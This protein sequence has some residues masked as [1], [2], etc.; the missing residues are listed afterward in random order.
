VPSWN[1]TSLNLLQ[2]SGPVQ[3][4]IGTGLPYQNSNPVIITPQYSIYPC[5]HTHASKEATH[6]STGAETRSLVR[7]SARPPLRRRH[8]N[9]KYRFLRHNPPF[10]RRRDT[11]R[12]LDESLHQTKAELQNV[13]QVV[14]TVQFGMS[15]RMDDGAVLQ[16]CR[17][18]RPH[19]GLSFSGFMNLLCKHLQHS[20]KWDRQH[21]RSLRTYG[22]HRQK[23]YIYIHVQWDSNSRPQ[24]FS[25]EV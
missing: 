5:C 23:C 12:Q 10:F 19:K 3:V 20:K 18:P 9:C 14:G 16:R 25:G 4:C 24:C 2:P 6:I 7:T 1:S 22:R 21:A 11:P 13:W 15:V 17:P 8:G